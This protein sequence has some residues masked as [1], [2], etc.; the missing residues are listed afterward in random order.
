MKRLLISAA[1]ALVT[2]IV[3][4]ASSAGA[5]IDLP[6]VNARI[7]NLDARVTNTERDIKTLQDST[8]TAP[9]THVDVP[10]APAPQ[11]APSSSPA[12]TP[13]ATPVPTPTATPS[14]PVT[15]AATPAPFVPSHYQ[16]G[17]DLSDGKQTGIE[18]VYYTAPGVSEHHHYATP[19]MTC[20]EQP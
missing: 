10:A 13:D 15:P 8:K 11:Q 6:Y 17:V 4:T 1:V 2:T 9:A 7:D 18:C 14:T 5:T 19:I 3:V 16:S 20:P 12:P